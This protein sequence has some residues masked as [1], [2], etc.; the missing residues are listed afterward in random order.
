MTRRRSDRLAALSPGT[1]G[2]ERNPPAL[3][4]EGHASSSPEPLGVLLVD[5][6]VE[7]LENLREILERRGYRVALATG[8][9][10]ALELAQREAI[11]LAVLD[12]NLP[13]GDGLSLLG[14]LRERYPELAGLVLTG[15]P[16]LDSA[17]E[18]LEAGAEG[19]LLKGAP[20]AELLA[21]LERAAAHLRL[22]REKR[23]LEA[24]LRE[25][26]RLATIG[27]LAARIAHEVRNPL[28]GIAGAVQLMGR[29]LPRGDPRRATV[30]EILQQ[31]RRLDGF[32]QDLLLYARPVRVRRAAVSAHELFERAMAVLRE[33]PA[34]SH[35]AVE[36]DDEAPEQPLFVDAGQC[37]AALQNLLLNAA[38]AQA[39]QEAG[40][41]VVRRLR[42]PQGGDR[43]VVED[44]GPGLDEQAQARLFEPFQSTRERGTGLGLST[45]KKIVEAHGGTIGGENREHGGARFTIELPPPEPERAEAEGAGAA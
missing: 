30:R 16:S 34:F 3:R 24:R 42:T 37:V 8:C 20:V 2:G 36:L 1:R 33:H 35:I 22:L 31:I 10:E 25:S 41:I 12:K 19:Y 26:E 9:A 28:A 4:R 17:I 21:A 13:D 18:A 45:V 40:R 44:E 7:L 29:G 6:N 27:E 11:D 15:Y 5:D 14:R 23:A 43:L 39:A 38:Q 32:I